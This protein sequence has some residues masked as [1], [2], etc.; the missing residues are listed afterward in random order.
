VVNGF[1]GIAQSLYTQGLYSGK[2]VLKGYNTGVV[3]DYSSRAGVAE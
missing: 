1:K 2:G 3:E